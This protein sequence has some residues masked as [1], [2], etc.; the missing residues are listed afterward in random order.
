MMLNIFSCVYWWFVYFFQRNVNSNYL[1]TFKIGGEVGGAVLFTVD[2]EEFFYSQNT[3]SLSD[4]DLQKYF[5][6]LW[7]IVSVSWRCPLMTK[8]FNFHEIQFIFPLS[9]V[10]LMSYL[11]NHFLTQGHEEL[12][13][14]IFFL[15]VLWL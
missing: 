2:L 1:P 12:F 9:L 7:I 15:G 3:S 10:F 5:S 11:R 8:S 14:C 6:I 13:L 4:N